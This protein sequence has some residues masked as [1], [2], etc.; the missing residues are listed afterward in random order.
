MI[1]AKVSP[2][3]QI[4]LPKEMLDALGIKPGDEIQ[5]SQAPNWLTLSRR[6]ND[7]PRRQKVDLTRPAPLHGKIDPHHEPFEI[8]DLDEVRKH[9]YVGS[10]LRN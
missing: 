4:K 9:M 6:V 7:V 10:P 5:I 3:G 1:T 2:E 8:E